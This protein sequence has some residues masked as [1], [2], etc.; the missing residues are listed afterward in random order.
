MPR[1]GSFWARY[2]ERGACSYQDAELQSKAK[3]VSSVLEKY[4]PRSL[5][6]L[7]CNTGLFS[8]LAAQQKCRVVALDTDAESVEQLYLNAKNTHEDITPFTMD[9]LNPTPRFG[10]C[11]KQFPAAHERIKGEMAFALAL[12]HHLA[13]TG[14][15]GFA[16]ALDAIETFSS[17]NVLLEWI[18]PEDPKVKKLIANSRRDYSWYSLD[19]LK[20]CLETRYKDIIYYSLHTPTRQFILY[21]T[22]H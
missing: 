12:I 5:V 10:W 19:E 22:Q 17:G 7:G 14:R 21:G 20:R 15:Q 8:R 13:I 18:S 16:R 9:V 6:D 3:I 1:R 11:G 2:Y 4:N